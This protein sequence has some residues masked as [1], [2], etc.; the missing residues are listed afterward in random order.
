M[1]LETDACEYG[2][3]A[4]LKEDVFENEF[5]TSKPIAYFS[6]SYTITQRKYSWSEKELLAIV[7][8]IKHFHSYLYGK[9]FTVYS[10]HLPLT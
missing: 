6:K 9:R 5:L 8:A 4:V 3:G 1:Y 2:Y 7:E 10:N